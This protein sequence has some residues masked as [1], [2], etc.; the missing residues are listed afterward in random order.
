MIY[1][2]L[3]HMIRGLPKCKPSYLLLV[4]TYILFWHLF[5]T[6]PFLLVKFKRFTMLNSIWML[7]KLLFELPFNTITW[8]HKNSCSWSRV[9]MLNCIRIVPFNMV[10][11]LILPYSQLLVS[12]VIGKLPSLKNPPSQ[13]L[14]LTSSLVKFQLSRRVLVVK[15][16]IVD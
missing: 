3:A 16:L 6:K 1:F 4:I 9:I 8:F 12:L 15:R 14:H 10:N 7:F 11:L 2:A 5:Y 13:Q